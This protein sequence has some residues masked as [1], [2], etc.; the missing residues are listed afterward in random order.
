M[1]DEEG[2]LELVSSSRWYSYVKQEVHGKHKSRAMLKM[3]I[4]NALLMCAKSIDVKK[5]Y[6]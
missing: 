5:C 2:G 1:T 4:C 3:T 6:T